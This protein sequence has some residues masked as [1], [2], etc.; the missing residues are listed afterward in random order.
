MYKMLKKYEKFL[1][2]GEKHLT[3]HIISD[4]IAL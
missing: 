2:T 1:K 3:L 4:I